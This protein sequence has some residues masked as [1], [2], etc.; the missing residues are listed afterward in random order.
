MYRKLFL[1]ILLGLVYF[2]NAQKLSINGTIQDTSARSPLKNAVI[3][4]VKLSDSTLIDFTRSNEVG[5]F[6]FNDLP[7]D[8]FKV[9]MSFPKFG[10]KIMYVIGSEKNNNIHFNSIIMPPKSVSLD[11]VTIFAYKDPIYYKGDTLIYTADSFKVKPNATVEDLLKRLPGVKVDSKGKITAQGKEVSKVL[12]D[13]DEFFGADPT[14]ATKNLAANSVE[15]VQ[16][17]EKKDENASAESTNDEMIKV[18][19]LKLKDDAKKGYF[20]KATA[21]SDAKDFYEGEL[22][23]NRFRNKQKVSVFALGA[24]TPKTGFGWSEIEKYGLENERNYSWDEEGGFVGKESGQGIPR[25]INTGIYYNDK[26]SKKTKI[27]TNYSYKNNLL[28]T[29]SDERSQYFFTDTNYVTTN[30]NKNTNE[31]QSHNFNLT[32]THDIDSVTKLQI[33]P[34]FNYYENRSTS[35]AK[36]NFATVSDF[37]TRGTENTNKNQSFGYD[38]SANVRLVRNFKKKDRILTLGYLLDKGGSTGNGQLKTVNSF[39]TSTVSTFGD[40]DQKKQSI[41]SNL[42][43]NASV[44]FFEPFTKKIKAEVTY[45]FTYN[46]NDQ[47]KKSLNSI[48]GDYSLLDSVYSNDFMNDKVVNQAKLRFIYSLK[49]YSFSIGTRGRNVSL[50]NTNNYTG[51]VFTQNVS[52]LLPFMNYNYNFNTNTH[53]YFNYNTNS[54]QP[55]I[56][57]LQPLP[58]NANQNFITLGNPNL[59]P[60]LAHQFNLNF[61]SYKPISGKYIWAGG[62]YNITQNAFSSNLIYDSLG[63]SISTPINIDGNYNGGGWLGGNFPMFGRVV[64]VNINASTNFYGNNNIING[65]KNTTKNTTYNGGLGVSVDLDKYFFEINGNYDYNIPYS[66]LNQVNNKPYTTQSYNFTGRVELPKKFFIESDANYNINS[67]RTNGYNINYI[68]VN[69]SFSKNFGKLENFITAIKAYDVFNQNVI[70]GRQVYNNIITD[71]KTKIITRYFLL[72]LTYKFNSQKTK[73]NDNDF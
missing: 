53:L 21:A 26:L 17:Y 19:N 34:K 44:M 35:Y 22:L 61:N 11:E 25:T 28:V 54:Q 67:N 73:E 23:L 20:G 18:M 24:N 45:E 15:S 57:Q 9:I 30:Y 56:N 69:A 32:I 48:N 39:Y 37:V 1:F 58:N 65:Q 6:E 49:K 47:L 5:Y 55:S 4:V 70:A 14:M 7:I 51:K 29:E 52:N 27:N 3:M 46:V 36:N 8:T 2:T 64:S 59:A 16:V 68:I 13:G 50:T 66:T 38:A 42:T 33:T 60:T 12:V 63:R 41:S 62:N 43:H 71:S 72:S 40:I 10:D 31:N